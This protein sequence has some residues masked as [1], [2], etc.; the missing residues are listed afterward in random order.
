MRLADG[1]NEYHGELPSPSGGSRR[2]GVVLLG[3]GERPALQLRGKTAAPECAFCKFM[4]AG[5]CGAV[6]QAWEDCIDRARDSGVDFVELCGK[7]RPR[8]QSPAAA[9]NLPR[10]SPADASAAAVSAR[11]ILPSP[12]ATP[13]RPQTRPQTRPP[14]DPKPGP[15]PD[16]ARPQTRP[17]PRPQETLELKR[18]TDKHPEYYG[19]LSGGGGGG[20]DGDDDADVDEQKAATA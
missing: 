1:S 3:A 14:H 16:P 2:L 17:D 11:P 19:E 13:T 7:A 10:S 5:P 12:N 15:K 4:K 18:C 20:D 8:P 9:A 6:F